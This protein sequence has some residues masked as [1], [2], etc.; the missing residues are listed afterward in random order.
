MKHL[1]H[2]VFPPGGKDTPQGAS[3]V[4]ALLLLSGLLDEC[5]SCLEELKAVFTW[6]AAALAVMNSLF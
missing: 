6:T 1:Q 5:E 3:V 2:I 4:T